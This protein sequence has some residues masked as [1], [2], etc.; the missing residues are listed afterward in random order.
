M[1]KVYLSFPISHFDIEER[2][3]FAEKRENLLSK[4][5]GYEVVNPLK[6]GLDAS[7]H[8]REHMKRDLKLLLECDTICL[9]E[10]YRESLGC[11]LE[12]KTAKMAGID[13]ISIDDNG[14]HVYE[15]VEVNSQRWLNLDNL[16]NELWCDIEGYEGYYQV[17]NYGRVKSMSRVIERKSCK[18]TINERIL[19]QTKTDTG[20]YCIS[21]KK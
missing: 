16:N 6:N 15:D 9:C 13:I 19:V 3:R 18:Q 4:V 20:Y 7:A 2:R 12:Y 11:H 21:L 1:K 17:S 8:W 10:C 14:V 5:Y